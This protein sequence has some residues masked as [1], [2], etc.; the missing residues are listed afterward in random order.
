M[1]DGLSFMVCTTPRSE[2]HTVRGT[3][4]VTNF[5]FQCSA[6]EVRSSAD[7]ALSSIPFIL[8]ACPYLSDCDQNM[9][10]AFIQDSTPF[11]YLL[12]RRE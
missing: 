8:L 1:S 11:G 7:Y 3:N 12:R 5:V 10:Y 2:Q 6:I 9:A 4:I